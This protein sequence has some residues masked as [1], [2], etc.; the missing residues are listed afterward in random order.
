[1]ESELTYG[2]KGEVPDQEYL[3]PL[4]KAKVRR[5]GGHVSLVTWGK[6][7]ANV[8]AA[9]DALA[10]DGIEAEVVDLRSLRPLDQ[11][12]LFAS[13]VKTGHCVVVHE[14]YIYGGLGAEVVARIQ[15]AC[16]D[17]LQG[18][19]L[20]VCN[21]DVN[22][23]YAANLEKLVMPSP[24]RIVEAARRCLGRTTRSDNALGA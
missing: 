2:V 8:E 14:G 21:R 22:Q 9:A 3:V 1:M 23:P 17:W 7:V 13:V 6:Q 20:R 4:G 5:A 18:P 12:T 24:E 15:E 11:E 10:R 19:V 16:F